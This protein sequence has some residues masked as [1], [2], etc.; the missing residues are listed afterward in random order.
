MRA[1]RESVV[2][3]GLGRAIENQDLSARLRVDLA[4]A[5]L[6]LKPA[7]FLLMWAASPFVFAAGAFVLG[8]VFSGLKNPVAIALFFAIGLYFPRFYLKYRQGK[9]V[10]LFGKQLPDTIT[11]LA[12]SLPGRLLLPA[13]SGT[14]HPR[15][16]AADQRGVRARGARDEP[17]RGA[18]AGAQQHGAPR[19]LRGPGADG[20]CHQHP[21]PGRRQPRHGP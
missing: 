17:G 8:F 7:E 1:D 16:E 6:K 2:V 12:N 10:K 21:E 14:D 4:R 5:D 15:G 19:R 20:D 11:L 13:G 3:A 9:R 18:P